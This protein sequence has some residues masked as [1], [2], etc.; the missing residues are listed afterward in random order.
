MSEHVTAGR[1]VR[2]PSTATVRAVVTMSIVLTLVHFTDNAV[3]IDTYPAPDWQPDWFWLVVVLSWP[4]FTAFGVL[5]YR[6]YARGEWTKAQVSLVIYSYTGLISAGHFLYGGPGELTT[7][8]VVSV[9]IDITVG[10]AVLA[11]ALWSIAARRRAI[12]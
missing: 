5:G 2:P 9:L 8:G 10:S 12:A 3:S 1:P 7:R 11:V 6:F 4:V